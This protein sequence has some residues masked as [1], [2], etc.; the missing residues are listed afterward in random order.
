VAIEALM[1]LGYEW[2]MGAK[3]EY[4]AAV[5][6]R[7]KSEARA[8]LFAKKENVLIAA[9]LFAIYV[10]IVWVSGGNSAA[11]SEI[12]LKIA[13]TIAPVLLYPVL[14][15]IKMVAVPWA[16]AAEQANHIESLTEQ[17]TAL[18]KLTITLVHGFETRLR[19]E[20][21]GQDV[22]IAVMIDFRDAQFNQAMPDLV[23][24]KWTDEYAP[25][26]RVIQEGTHNSI[27]VRRCSVEFGRFRETYF[28]SQGMQNK[29]WGF[30][31]DSVA[32]AP[33]RR[34]ALIVNSNP[35]FAGGP[36]RIVFVERAFQFELIEGDVQIEE[37]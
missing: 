27:L 28:G 24:P 31:F 34:V 3:R 18:P 7:A 12:V 22:T 16:L 14:L 6:R 5:Y 15:L 2:A 35:R 8:E 20:N 26:M 1:G 19:F 23:E 33:Q 36:K 13:A 37:D 30:E 21:A 11:E 17:L 4:W 29:Q 25:S 32:D 9:V 10:A